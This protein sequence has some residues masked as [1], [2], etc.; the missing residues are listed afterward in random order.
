MELGL[1]T[2]TQVEGVAQDQ[3]STG[4]LGALLIGAGILSHADLETTLRYQRIL[5]GKDG[6]GEVSDL[7][8]RQVE[9]LRD[10]VKG[11]RAMVAAIR[12]V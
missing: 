6:P 2:T 5:R 9:L 12:K 1:C 10:E 11:L 4:F 7:R 8:R 3:L